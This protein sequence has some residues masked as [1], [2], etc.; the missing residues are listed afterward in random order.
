MWKP[1]VKPFYT[2]SNAHFSR[3]RKEATIAC[4]AYCMCSE[5]VCCDSMEVE[6]WGLWFSNLYQE[7]LFRVHHKVYFKEYFVS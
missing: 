2:T 4:A 7:L 3:P 1:A 6:V 5:N